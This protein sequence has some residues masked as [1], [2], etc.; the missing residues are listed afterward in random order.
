MVKR[1]CDAMGRGSTGERQTSTRW[2]CTLAEGERA[3]DGESLINFILIL[4]LCNAMIYSYVILVTGISCLMV[5]ML[6]GVVD[7]R[8]VRVEKAATSSQS[9]GAGSSFFSRQS[10][11]EQ[12]KE[13]L[14]Q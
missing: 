2:L 11:I 13:T 14:R 3:M 4:C 6:N 5:Y 12:L 1:W 9:T 7:Y 10:K 8:H